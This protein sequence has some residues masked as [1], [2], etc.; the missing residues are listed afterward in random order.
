MEAL[1]ERRFSRVR[2][3]CGVGRGFKDKGK[4]W[5]WK[6]A[7]KFRGNCQRGGRKGVARARPQSLR[8]RGDGLPLWVTALPV[9]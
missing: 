7:L 9:I 4:G 5:W 2:V 6:G 8:R 3:G 1:E